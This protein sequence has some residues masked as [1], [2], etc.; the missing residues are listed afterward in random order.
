MSK[1]IKKKVVI[2][3]KFFEWKN[4]YTYLIIFVLAFVFLLFTFVRLSSESLDE[5]EDLKIPERE[6][7][8]QPQRVDG[9]NLTNGDIAIEFSTTLVKWVPILIIIMVVFTVGISLLKMIFVFDQI[10]VYYNLLFYK[11]YLLFLFLLL[12][13]YIF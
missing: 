12:V 4:R 5:T 6:I 2:E 8:E 13:Y 11:V 3:P 9:D 10:T 1:Q 7:K